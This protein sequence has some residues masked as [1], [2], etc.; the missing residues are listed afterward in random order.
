MIDTTFRR[1]RSLQPD[2]NDEFFE[3]GPQSVTHQQVLSDLRFAITCWEP[4]KN[5]F[6]AFFLDEFSIERVVRRIVTAVLVKIQKVRCRIE[7]IAI[8][9]DGGELFTKRL[10]RNLQELPEA[11]VVVNFPSVAIEERKQLEAEEFLSIC[12]ECNGSGSLECPKCSGVGTKPCASCVGS[13]LEECRICRGAG[14][15]LETATTTR[16]CNSCSGNGTH[17]CRSCKGSRNH[18]C[19]APGCTNGSLSCANC[20]SSGKL[21][22]TTYLCIDS[23]VKFGHHLYCK[24]GWVD[25]TSELATDL[26]ILRAENLTENARNVKVES[27]RSLLPDNLR[28]DAIR[29]GREIAAQKTYD[30]WDIGVCYELRV[31]YV[32]HVVANHLHTNT[33]LVVSGCSNSVTV[34]VPPEQPRGLFKKLGRKMSSLMSGDQVRNSEHV[35]SVRAGDA[36][37]SDS[38]LIGPA[39]RKHGL[40]VSLNPDGYDVVIPDFIEGA[41]QAQVNF[42]FDAAGRVTLHCSVLLGEADRDFFPEA[43]MLSNKLPVGNI[44]LQELNGGNIERFVLVNRQ[45]Y[46]NTSPP[47][48]AYLLRLMLSTAFL[49]RKNNRI[50]LSC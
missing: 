1:V 18:K 40:Q 39:L 3:D 23:F 15:V 44:A 25:P 7:H 2:V 47:H 36:F 16:R 28:Q 10:P 5:Q 49:L 33:E 46:S 43:L 42:S 17:T 45:P 6:S 38:A 9:Y 37:F 31:G 24:D 32:Y 35:D 11:R 12:D 14:E 50:G 20:K 41:N 13:G 22:N 27:L 8:P 19:D 26:M 21:R 48:L 4:P 29:I 30:S 34:L